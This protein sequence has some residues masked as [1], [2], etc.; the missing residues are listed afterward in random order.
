MKSSFH[1][2]V[3]KTTTVSC[4][5]G[6]FL[7]LQRNSVPVGRVGLQD[8][9]RLGRYHIPTSAFLSPH[10]FCYLFVFPC[11]EKT[12]NKAMWDPVSQELLVFSPRLAVREVFPYTVLRLRIFFIRT[13]EPS[14]EASSS[15]SNF[16]KQY[17]LLLF[18]SKIF[19]KI[20]MQPLRLFSLLWFSFGSV[21]RVYKAE[22]HL[23]SC[24]WTVTRSLKTPWVCMWAGWA[25]PHSS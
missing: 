6:G 25:W 22:G 17:P 5:M 24:H 13:P 23:T 2:T 21:F 3:K 10:P 8:F 11:E 7:S 19:R 16:G 14:I 12:A 1:R 20:K 15:V 18:I 9:P 4:L